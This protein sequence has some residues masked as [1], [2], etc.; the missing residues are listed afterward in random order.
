VAERLRTL[1][2]REVR[3]KR[4]PALSIALVD[5]QRIVWSH[6]FGH[7]DRDGKVPASAETVYRV[8]SVSK[9]FTD[10]AIMQLVERGKID[11]DAPVTKYLPNFAPVNQFDD[12]PITLR[13]LMAHRSGLVREPP[14]GNYFDPTGPTLAQTVASL[15]GLELVYPPGK[16]TKYSN[17]AIGVVGYVLEKTQNE[18]FETYLKRNVLDPLGMTSSAFEPTPTVKK[19]LADAV[20]WSYHGRE[21]PAPTFELGMSPAG[22]MYSTVLDLSKFLSCLF[23]DG[24]IGDKQLLKPAT[25]AEMFRPQFAKPEEKRGFGI[26]FALGELDGHR[27]IG[28]GGAIYGFAT[29]VSALP[30]DKLGVVVVASRDVANAVVSHV[31]DVALQLMLAAKQGKPLPAVEA[32]APLPRDEARKLAGHYRSG[33]RWFDLVESAGRLWIFQ[34]RAV[35]RVELRG[36]GDDLMADGVLTIGPKMRRLPDGK[37][38]L[39]ENVYE[40]QPDNGP[41]PAAPAK[42]AGLI[43]EYGWDHNTLYIHERHGKLYALIE[44][45][46]LDPLTEESEN[47]FAFPDRGLYH[48]QKLVFTRDSSGRAT[49]VEAA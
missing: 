22:S 10:V 40:K 2:E 9:L 42:W 37:L 45:I 4:L 3:D 8:G 31:A 6:G 21:F 7:Q 34:D 36:H 25:I 28:H 20:M 39:G 26:G 14:V 1:L 24:K 47:V 15:N 35:V 23:A 18:K 48:G 12:K 32:S 41:P 38:K 44:W 5:N 13:H 30:D 19:N 43:G 49:Q 33:E 27:R 11:L 17:A 16:R 29:D 46:E